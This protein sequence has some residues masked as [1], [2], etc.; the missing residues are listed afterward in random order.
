MTVFERYPKMTL[1]TLLIL[2]SGLMLVALEWGAKTFFGLG[3]VVIYETHPLYGYRPSP[4]QQVSRTPHA[5]VSINNLGLRANT[6]WEFTQPHHK[7]LFLGDS[8]TYGGSY[9]SN[10]D[11]FS[12]LAVKSLPSWQAGNAGVNGWGV[13]NVSA[14]ILTQQFLPADVYVS[15]FPEGDFYRG[16]N[17]IGGQPLW[18]VKPRF[19]LEELFHYGLYQLQLRKYPATIS[20]HEEHVATPAIVEHAVQDLKALHDYLTLQGKIHLIYISPTQKQI[21]EQAKFDPIVK[22]MLKKYRLPVI[23]IS[24]RLPDV[25]KTQKEAW[26]H[27]SIHLSQTGHRQWSQIIADD[28]NKKVS[29]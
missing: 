28:L 3:H 6:D 19:A 4:N 1:A 18:T 27:D 20:Y 2:L 7:V 14:F 23:Y 5:S 25:S 12:Q 10:E 26:F 29:S 11:L 17:R 8:V 24:D 22:S 13:S 16:I 9:I 15:V 21:V